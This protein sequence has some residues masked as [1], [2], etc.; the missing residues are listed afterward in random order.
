MEEELF[1]NIEK[2]AQAENFKLPYTID[3][4]MGSWT[5]QGGH[6]LLTVERN[7]VDGSFTVKQTQFFDDS[8]L[9]NNDKRFIV[10]FN[11]ATG[12]LS[13]FVNTI[14]THFLKED[15]TKVDAKLAKD[16]F[17]I[18]NKQSTGFFNIQY[19][20]E[21]WKLI[22]QALRRRHFKI[23]VL[24]R[25]QLIFDA[26]KLSSSSRLEYDVLMDLLSYLEA[27]E[28]YAPWSTA[29]GIL[30]NFNFYFQGNKEALT[31]FKFFITKITDRIYDK[32]G[33]SDLPNERHFDR[34]LRTTI[35]N[36]ACM[37][38]NEK[39]LTQTTQKLAGFVEQNTPIEANLK[40]PVFCN[41][42]KDADEETF[43]KVH[44]YML[45]SD[46][47][48]ERRSLISALGCAQRK[49]N[50][51]T[52]LK[53]TID[54]Q[55]GYKNNEESGILS[56]SYSR[57]E[58]GLLASIDFLSENYNEYYKLNELFGGKKPLEADLE[59]MPYYITTKE[60]KQ[61]Y[62]DLVKKIR[63]DAGITLKDSLEANAATMAEAN[64]AWNAK[65]SP[66]V[67]KWLYSYA[68]G[69]AGQMVA[70]VFTVIGALFVSKYLM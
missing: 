24:N 36:L 20:V 17:L 32:L 54:K 12:N 61:K 3:E 7:Y 55:A 41:G 49:E 69:G 18:L 66:K 22:S 56:S 15:S 5:R 14:A 64:I 48:A 52:Y 42:L 53:S 19:D 21:N 68:R 44:Q 43:T 23:H 34:Y 30:T 25:A 31:D 28:D 4:M 47:A 50:V 27:E 38:G 39:C 59:N 37:G 6:P 45:A 1:K 62:D 58:V 13:D 26:N 65:N 33:A 9:S 60:N 51:E 46:D 70:S 35:M 63:A 67:A 10:P 29:S 8:T 2:S 11:Y 16:E 40:T 57:G